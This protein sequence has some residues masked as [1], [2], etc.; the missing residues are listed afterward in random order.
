MPYKI[1]L[2]KSIKKKKKN[3]WV[4]YKELFLCFNKWIGLFIYLFLLG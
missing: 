3:P 4:K 2:V 1:S